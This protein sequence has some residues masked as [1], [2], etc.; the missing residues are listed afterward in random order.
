MEVRLSSVTAFEKANTLGVTNMALTYRPKFSQKHNDNN[1]VVSKVDI[2]IAAP[3]TNRGIKAYMK[4]SFTPY[5]PGKKSQDTKDAVL[6]P[7]VGI[8][9][10]LRGAL[11]IGVMVP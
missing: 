7:F 5:A 2:A 9:T 3:A 4:E 8:A 1:E 11:K 10:G 6:S